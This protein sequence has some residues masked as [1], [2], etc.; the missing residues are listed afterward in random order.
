MS[1]TAIEWMVRIAAVIACLSLALDRYSWGEYGVAIG[2]LGPAVEPI[3]AWQ[4]IASTV[5]V[6]ALIASATMVRVR[7]PLAF[8]LGVGAA[9]IYLATNV[10][11]FARDGSGR[12]VSHD[13]LVLTPGRFFFFGAAAITVMSYGLVRLVRGRARE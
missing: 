1:R 5:V 9:L 3:T 2:S 7:L 10:I 13:Y 4:P 11:L 12:L 6:L 8:G